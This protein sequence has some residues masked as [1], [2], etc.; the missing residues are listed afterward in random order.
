MDFIERYLGFAP[1]HGDG[2]FEAML[3]TM[4]VIVVA[5]VGLVF[6]GKHVRE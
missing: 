3:L 1:D 6:F 5:G 2:S 4:L